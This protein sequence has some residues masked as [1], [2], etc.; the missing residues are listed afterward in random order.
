MTV[1]QA[2]AFLLLQL[3][4]GAAVL[5]SLN[6]LSILLGCAVLGADRHLP[7]H[8]ADHLLAAAFPRAQFQLGR[9]DRLDRGHRRARP[10]R[11]CCS[12]SAAC[13]GPSATTRSTRIRT[14]R[15][16]PGSASNPRRSRSGAAP[17]RSCSR[18]TSRRAAA[19][20]GSRAR[21][22]ARRRVLGGA[23]RRG[24]CQLAWQAA[25]V[26]TDDPAD[27]LAKFRSNRAVGWLLLGRHRRRAFH[28]KILGQRGRQAI[29]YTPH[30][31]FPS[32]PSNPF[33]NALFEELDCLPGGLVMNLRYVLRTAVLPTALSALFSAGVAV[34]S[35]LI[36]IPLV[37]QLISTFTDAFKV[38]LAAILGLALQLH[39]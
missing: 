35:G 25:R 32:G 30:P 16:T 18:S 1:R 39:F 15:T 38:G 36:T 3:A 5:F 24:R 8:E 10:G 9:A 27:C 37:D 6:R 12:I 31:V 34:A 20:G 21:R 7:V 33:S 11:R 14:R 23:R 2:V 26:D 28:L 4:V 17:G 22:R 13:S 29:P 19:V